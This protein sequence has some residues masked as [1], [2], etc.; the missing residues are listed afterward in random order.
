VIHFQV[1]IQFSDDAPREQLKVTKSEDGLINEASYGMEASLGVSDPSPRDL[2][3]P[4]ARCAFIRAFLRE[5]FVKV[6]A[7]FR[8]TLLLPC[9][10]LYVVGSSI[11]TPSVSS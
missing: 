1:L 2:D 11:L 5:F 10:C 8:L 4:N 3:P 6:L 9:W 7:S